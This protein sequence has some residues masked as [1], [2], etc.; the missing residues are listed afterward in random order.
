MSYKLYVV[1]ERF[2]GSLFRQWVCTLTEEQS[3]S[4]NEI[5]VRVKNYMKMLG[6]GYYCC[7]YY[8]EYR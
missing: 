1:V 7:D 6:H 2:D 5:Q 8:L 3:R 4:F